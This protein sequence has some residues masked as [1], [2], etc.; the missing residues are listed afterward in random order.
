VPFLQAI[1]AAGGLAS[2]HSVCTADLGP[3]MQSISATIQS[4]LYGDCLTF[5]PAGGEDGRV[6][7]IL[8]EHPADRAPCPP[9]RIDLGVLRYGEGALAERYCQVCQT[10]DGIDRLVD[11]RGTDLSACAAASRAGDTWEVVFQTACEVSGTL[12]L[13]GAAQMLPDSSARILCQPETETEH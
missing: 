8:V 11:E 4:R 2:V 1:A 10:G 6:R 12:R 13:H 9:S 5:R 7:C 3:A